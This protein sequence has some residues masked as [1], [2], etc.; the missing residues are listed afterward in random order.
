MTHNAILGTQTFEDIQITAQG[1]ECVVL[2]RKVKAD[3]GVYK[4]GQILAEDENHELV[5][6]AYEEATDIGN[7]TGTETEFAGQT[8]LR[9]L[10]PGTVKVN[11]GQGTPQVLV[12]DG[13]GRLYGDGS[14][15][16]NYITGEVT[17]EFTTA[18]PD[19]V[20][21][22]LTAKNKPYGV[23]AYR[24]DTAQEGAANVN[25]HGAVRKAALLVGA[26]APEAED[27][28]LLEALGIYPI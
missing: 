28:R 19:G 2:A 13:C 16:V 21:I 4:A 25:V 20:D 22:F 26:D 9:N 24:V 6:F 11:D 17:V 12:D 7:G 5:P 8:T 3:N 10:Q 15:T 23:C 18:V 27:L 14:G 1:H